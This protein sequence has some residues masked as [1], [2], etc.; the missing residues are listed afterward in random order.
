MEPEPH[1]A[2]RRV[3]IL[4]ALLAFAVT[5]RFAG[6]AEVVERCG[7][8]P[9]PASPDFAAHLDE[10]MRLRAE[11]G[12]EP[13]CEQLLATMSPPPLP[14]DPLEAVA[15]RLAFQPIPLGESDFTRY[16]LLRAAPDFAGGP[17][18]ASALRRYFTGPSGETIELFEFDTSL[19]GR[20]FALDPSPP[21]ERVKGFDARLTIFQTKTGK[22]VSVL[23]WEENRRYIELRVNRNIRKE[24][25]AELVR[26][27]ESMPAP[28]PAQPDAPMTTIDD[29]PPPFGRG[30]R[31]PETPPPEFPVH[32]P[33]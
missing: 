10:R 31:F 5:A 17:R 4:L 29:A 28:V 16:R 11:L 14:G 18:G 27:A 1:A 26:I 20:V 23:S 8:G 15:H 22:A 19:G 9:S 6:G 3:R 30:A 12:Y 21:S 32:P 33:K 25:Y 24:G 13:V 7:P 2:R